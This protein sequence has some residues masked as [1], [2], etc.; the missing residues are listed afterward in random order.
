MKN[1]VSIGVFAAFLGGG[2]MAR[3]EAQPLSAR[4]Q[5]LLNGQLPQPSERSR[6]RIVGNE[7]PRE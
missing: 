7:A 4:C 2:T 1:Y 5:N 6:C 3:A